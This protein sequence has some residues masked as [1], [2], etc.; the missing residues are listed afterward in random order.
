[1]PDD[2]T[3]TQPADFGLT[4]FRDLL[5]KRAPFPG[6]PAALFAPFRQQLLAALEPATPY[7]CVLADGLVELEW[8]L[9]QHRRMRDEQI[10]KSLAGIVREAWRN[11]LSQRHEAL[12]DAE[13]EEWI[14]AGKSEDDF[15]GSPFDNDEATGEAIEMALR[16]LDD[17]LETASAAQAECV[18]AGISLIGLL[19]DAHNG[20]KPEYRFHEEK[21][22]DLEQRRRRLMADYRGMQ[23]ARALTARVVSK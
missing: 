16:L 5:P 20:H 1:M 22:N 7:E 13:W 8:E 4:S 15:E 3:N 12:L 19:S 11:V 23:D 2:L 6:E 18:A 17:D 14:E 21:V 9:Q 10:R